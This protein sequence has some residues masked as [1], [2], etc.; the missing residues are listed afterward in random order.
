MR[1]ERRRI[2]LPS[3]VAWTTMSIA[4]ALAGAGCGDDDTPTDAE[5]PRDVAVADAPVRDS[6]IRDSAIADVQET[7]FCIPDG[8]IDSGPAFD[9]ATCG[10]VVTDIDDCP[11]GCRAVG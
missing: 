2:R 7:F 11:P 10:S 3:Q 1:E 4:L 9:A 5:P 6:A 8:E